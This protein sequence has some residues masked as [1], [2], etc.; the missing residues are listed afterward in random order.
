MAEKKAKGVKKVTLLKRCVVREA[1]EGKT[2]KDFNAFDEVSVTATDAR[3]LIGC[4]SAADQGT[5]EGKEAIAEAKAA[6]PKPA[7]SAKK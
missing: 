4:G 2:P 6:L 7:K 3:Y 5:D 1:G